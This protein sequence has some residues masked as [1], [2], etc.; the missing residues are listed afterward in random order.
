MH[1]ARIFTLLLTSL[2]LTPLAS[3][4]SADDLEPVKIRLKWTHQ[5]Q[6]AGYYAAL[7]QGY[8]E[9]AGFDVEI[10]PP[11]AGISELD[12]L[13]QGAVEFAASDATAI[14]HR[15]WGRPVVLVRP[16][17]QTNPMVLITL[18][19]SG[20]EVAEDLRGKRLMYR[21]HQSGGNIEAFLFNVDLNPGD[22][23]ELPHSYDVMSLVRGEVDAMSVYVTDQPFRLQNSD[24]QSRVID[25][26]DYGI[27]F[28]GDLL[29]T[30]ERYASL[31]PN[32]A[33]QFGEATLKG[34]EYAR[35]HPEQ[36]V[37]LIVDKYAPDISRSKLRYEAD[38][39]IQL[40]EAG[41]VP[42]G[43]IDRGRLFSMKNQF[44]SL[45]HLR[46]E[47]DLEGLVLSDFINRPWF[48]RLTDQQATALA[49]G[50]LLGLAIILML[51]LFTT[52]LRVKVAEQTG[53]LR[54][55][56]REL[57]TTVSELEL[58]RNRAD[59]ASRAKD[60]FLANMS[61]E[62]RTPM[63]GIYGSL[64]ILNNTL[65]T[66]DSKKLVG[67]ALVASQHLL[68]ILNDILDLAKIKAGKLNIEISAFDLSELITNT[69]GTYTSLAEE[70]RLFFKASLNLDQNF[71]LSDP[72]RIKQILGNLISN[73]I[74]FTHTGSI[75]IE[76]TCNDSD[77]ILR[78]EDSGIGLDEGVESRIFSR[79]EQADGSTTRQYGGTGL[80][81]SISSALAEMLG[82]HLSVSSEKDKGS[83]FTLQVPIE[84]A[85]V[86]LDEVP[87]NL[88]STPRLSDVRVLVAEDNQLNQEVVSMMLEDHGIQCELVD[89][90][91]Q[92]VEAVRK[93]PPD[94]VLMD[95]QMPV[96][97]GLEATQI[98]GREYPEL[99]VIA[100]TANVMKDDIAKYRNSGFVAHVGKPFDEDE[101]MGM[102]HRF[103]S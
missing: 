33:D 10:Q 51:A 52:R 77:L 69:L 90:G 3:F 102:I 58:A 57:Q 85:D 44:K 67:G 9:D 5:F 39:T 76:A 99:P 40:L 59:E 19:D 4:T 7:E 31:F 100:L 60:L 83:V 101:L 86:P 2:L 71:V 89:D 74:K 94:V 23:S 6:F 30:S 65:Q 49:A 48:R 73:A 14:L 17:F 93:H 42:I 92:A 41:G 72:L 68:E 64:Q 88:E 70:K 28:Y 36:L 66:D 18:E 13:E 22:Y 11:I 16:I 91:Q 15:L 56:N 8:Y 63:N 50:T 79:C 78:V 37:D 26:A 54:V 1:L 80:G 46:T 24:I 53:E 38:A 97:D 81:L 12:A 25:P 84:P 20:I 45:G 75:S 43:T 98:I 35:D 47:S 27:D 61:H 21:R 95:V 103:V 34:W 32:R 62:I 96:M 87:V 82:G 55:A 29:V